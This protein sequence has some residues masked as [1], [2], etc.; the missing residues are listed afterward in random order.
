MMIELHGEKTILRTLERKHCR[1]LWEAYE[2]VEPLPTEPLNPGMSIEGAD[3]WFEEM[4]AKQGK[5]QV[6]L[7][8]F[9]RD[10]KLLGDLQLSGIDWRHRVAGIGLSIAR[11]VDRGQGYGRDATMT[12]LRYA[13]HQLDLHRVSAGT[14][15]HNLAAQRVLEKC[16]FVQEGEEREAIYCG[17]Q[18]WG[19]V[20]YGMLRG[21]FAQQGIG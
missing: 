5:E 18:R 7:G 21:E 6:Y 12:L 20:N 16:G 4:Q 13:F 8:V 2:P 14:A 15:S 1:E 10:G 3:T 19:R 9:A 17:G 11:K